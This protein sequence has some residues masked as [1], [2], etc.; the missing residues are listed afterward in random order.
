MP[1]VYDLLTV[2]DVF[3]NVD[4][5]SSKML[6]LDCNTIAALIEILYERIL[7]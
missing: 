2:Y 1:V 5:S 7:Q 3:E 6:V 4:K